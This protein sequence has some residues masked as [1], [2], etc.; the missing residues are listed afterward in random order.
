MSE[1]IPQPNPALTAVGFN[2]RVGRE[3][4][5]RRGATRG[6]L[7]ARP[8]ADSSVATRRGSASVPVRGLKPT[9]TFT[10]RAAAWLQCKVAGALKPAGV[11]ESNSPVIPC[12][13][14][15]TRHLLPA[16]LAELLAANDRLDGGANA[17]FVGL[18]LVAHLGNQGSV[19][20]QHAA[21]Q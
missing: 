2:P 16:N 21:A 13:S 14:F 12:L 18:Q 3:R 20:E 8:R 19:G 4:S 5:G 7:I 6:R 11:V 10:C 9:A 15:L 17:V 1:E